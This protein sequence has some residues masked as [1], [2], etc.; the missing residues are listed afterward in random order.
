MVERVTLTH[1][2]LVRIQVPQSKKA[3]PSGNAFLF[4]LLDFG[5]N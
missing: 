2:V 1:L 5:E 3:F 4:S